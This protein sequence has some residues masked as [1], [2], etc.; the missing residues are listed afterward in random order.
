VIVSMVRSL[1]A[2]LWEVKRSQRSAEQ[3]GR[4]SIFVVKGAAP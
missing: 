1:R 2:K 4:L 3:D